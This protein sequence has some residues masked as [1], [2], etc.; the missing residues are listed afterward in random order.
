MSA[1]LRILYLPYNFLSWAIA[2]E[3]V[4]TTTMVF[5]DDYKDISLP[6]EQVKFVLP[7]KGDVACQVSHLALLIAIYQGS[8]NQWE[9]EKIKI[10]AVEYIETF[11]ATIT[12]DTECL[13]KIVD[14][15]ETTCSYETLGRSDYLPN[16]LHPALLGIYYLHKNGLIS[17]G[18]IIFYIGE[19][20]SALPW[21]DICAANDWAVIGAS[22][23]EQKDAFLSLASK[24][25]PPE[26]FNLLTSLI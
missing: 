13:N 22:I 18:R 12:K 23:K 21:D 11:N 1:D 20:L 7:C 9:P 10:N 5:W 19:S 17:T 8:L 14:S 26:C 2:K 6:P 24:K 25:I 3:L 15:A 16:M 4:P